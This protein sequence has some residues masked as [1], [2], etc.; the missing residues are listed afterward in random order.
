MAVAFQVIKN[1]QLEAHQIVSLA[2]QRQGCVS[3]LWKRSKD[4]TMSRDINQAKPLQKSDPEWL[5]LPQ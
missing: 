3:A 5:Y 4:M 2:S 1:R